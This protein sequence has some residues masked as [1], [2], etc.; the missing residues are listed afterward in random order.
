MSVMA[1]RT[2]D[3]PFYTMTVPLDGS[4]YMLEFRYNQRENAWYFSVSLTDGTLLAA[5]IKVVCNRSLL[6]RFADTRLPPGILLAYANTTDASTPGMGELGQGLRAT[7][8]YF[9]AAEVAAV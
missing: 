4:D 5:G 2:F 9:D 7:L 1:L 6:S 8:T 3:D